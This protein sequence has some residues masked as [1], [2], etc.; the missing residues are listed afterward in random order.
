MI[1]VT[2]FFSQVNWLSVNWAQQ[3][4]RFCF[5]AT[6][7]KRILLLR[8]C[9]RLWTCRGIY[10]DI[11]YTDR[12]PSY[13]LLCRVAVTSLLFIRTARKLPP[14]ARTKLSPREFVVKY[15]LLGLGSSSIG[16]IRWTWNMFIV[17][18]NFNVDLS[19]SIFFANLILTTML[20]VSWKSVAISRPYDHI[21]LLFPPTIYLLLFFWGQCKVKNALSFTSFDAVFAKKTWI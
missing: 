1:A 15:P 2:Q 6:V 3:P 5:S 21:L 13:W 19:E 12:P 4:W 14:S 7:F 20:T 9:S 18:N 8:I 17:L 10:K 16:P 11:W